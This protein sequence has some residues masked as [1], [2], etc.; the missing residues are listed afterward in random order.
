[1]LCLSIWMSY[2]YDFIGLKLKEHIVKTQNI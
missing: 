1:M 2:P